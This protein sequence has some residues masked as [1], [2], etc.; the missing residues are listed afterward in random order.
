MGASDGDRSSHLASLR[1][2]LRQQTPVTIGSEA[3]AFRYS[4]FCTELRT[5]QGTAVA[6]AVELL[7]NTEINKPARYLGNELGAVHKPWTAAQVRWVLTYP[8]VYEVG[9]SNLG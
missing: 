2:S 7:L 4:V 1:F 5:L 9:A 3:K 8:E 6:V